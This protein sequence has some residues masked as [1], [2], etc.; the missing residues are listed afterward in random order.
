MWTT[1]NE[2][3]NTCIKVEDRHFYVLWVQEKQFVSNFLKTLPEFGIQIYRI[4][5]LW[6][7]RENFKRLSS[8]ELVIAQRHLAE[9]EAS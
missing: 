5:T 6:Q 9:V 1:D 8:S 7:S 4:C 3:V 2:V